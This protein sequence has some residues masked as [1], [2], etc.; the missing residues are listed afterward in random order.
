[1]TTE[2]AKK[3]DST[4]ADLSLIPLVALEQMARAFMFGEKRYGRYNYTAGFDSHR[5]IAAA[6]RHISQWQNG[7]DQDSESGASHLGHALASLAMLLHTMA[8]GTNKDTRLGKTVPA[9]TSGQMLVPGVC[10][11]DEKGG[12]YLTKNAALKGSK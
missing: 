2:P 7:E 6:M 3:N 9:S 10:E 4:K 5:L 1:M 11:V 8:L 12:V